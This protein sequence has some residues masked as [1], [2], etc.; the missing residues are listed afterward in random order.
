[1][2]YFW[3][4]RPKLRITAAFDNDPK[5]AGRVIQGCRCYLI[6]QMCEM[7]QERE[8]KTAIITVP[9]DEA[10]GIAD[11]LVGAGIR[12]IVNFAPVRIRVPKGVFV[13]DIDMAIVLEKVAYFAQE[14]TRA[15][16]GTAVL[17]TKEI[18]SILKGYPGAKRD[19]LIP[20]LQDMQRGV[21]LSVS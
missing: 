19:S 10:Q 11:I 16:K 6:D 14:A 2:K 17:A 21:G 20:I 4:R 9:V 3:G 1:M 12:G 18:D 15:V 13:E 5:K 7:I 8:I